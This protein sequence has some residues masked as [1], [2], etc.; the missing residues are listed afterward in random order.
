M[1]AHN[2]S[3][4]SKCLG[5]GFHQLQTCE[6]EANILLLLERL[7]V[8]PVQQLSGRAVVLTFEGGE[9][10]L[11]GGGRRGAEMW[12][13]LRGG[14]GHQFASARD[15]GLSVRQAADPAPAPA[16]ACAYLKLLPAVRPPLCRLGVFA[17]TVRSSIARYTYVYL[18]LQQAARLPPSRLQPPPALH[19]ATQRSPS[20]A[21]CAQYLRSNVR[22]AWPSWER[23]MSTNSSTMINTLRG[24]CV[25]FKRLCARVPCV[26]VRGCVACLGGRFC[27]SYSSV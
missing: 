18:L 9:W 6:A 20:L 16:P 19:A 8:N 26:R 15:A 22:T 3:T 25:S 5:S 17:W 14:A 7:D 23:L 21:S 11:G 24:A 13:D 4:N 12:C 27:G 1:T 10:D 2:P